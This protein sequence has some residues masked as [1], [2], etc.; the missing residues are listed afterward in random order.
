MP[1]V[2]TR[3]KTRNQHEVPALMPK[4]T[5]A[6][7]TPLIADVTRFVL[8]HRRLVTLFWLIVNVGQIP[9]DDGKLTSG[10]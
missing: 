9:V 2:S 3:E 1:T 10:G 7:K 6:A 5:P 4:P 8:R